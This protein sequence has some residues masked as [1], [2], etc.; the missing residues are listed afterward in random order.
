MAAYCGALG[1]RIVEHPDEESVLLVADGRIGPVD[2]DDA[3][4]RT[5]VVISTRVPTENHK[6]VGGLAFLP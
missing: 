1:A 2:Q 4:G 6:K 3:A 5:Q